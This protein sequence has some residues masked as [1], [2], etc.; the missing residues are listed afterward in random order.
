MVVVAE[1]VVVEEVMAGAPTEAPGG[2]S[3][4]KAGEGR[5]TYQAAGG[6]DYSK[7]GC[8]RMK[9]RR[10][11]KAHGPHTNTKCLGRVS[12]YPPCLLLPC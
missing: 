4:C 12:I 8:L 7:C 3:A 10:L 11:Q 2:R 1:V 9:T 6:R 5:N